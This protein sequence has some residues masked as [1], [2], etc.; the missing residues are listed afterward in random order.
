MVGSVE[1]AETV[2]TATQLDKKKLLQAGA[3][4]QT[5][6]LGTDEVNETGRN[7]GVM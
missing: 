3:L 1:T 4:E 2:K 5:M 7:Q 6:A